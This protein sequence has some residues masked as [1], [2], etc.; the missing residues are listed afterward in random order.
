MCSKYHRAQIGTT[1]NCPLYCQFRQTI[2]NGCHICELLSAVNYKAEVS[3]SKICKKVF[4]IKLG[5]LS[6]YGVVFYAEHYE[7]ND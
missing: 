6:D 4:V 2:V 5:T 3:E 1:F 7:I